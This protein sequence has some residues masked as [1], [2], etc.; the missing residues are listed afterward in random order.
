MMASKI[1]E[2]QLK[3]CLLVEHGTDEMPHSLY[4][5][6]LPS[7]LERQTE[8]DSEGFQELLPLVVFPQRKFLYQTEFVNLGSKVY[9]FGGVTSDKLDEDLYR[10]VHVL[11]MNDPKHGLRRVASLNASKECPCAF[12]AD[13]MIYTLGKAERKEAS[14]KSGC[15]ERY[16]P[17]IDRWEVLP[18][19]PLPWVDLFTADWTGRVTVVGREVFIGSYGRYAIFNLDTLEWAEPPSASLAECFPYGALYIDGFLYHLRGGDLWR[20]PGAVWD[21]HYVPK[22]LQIV[23]RGPFP[24][25]DGFGSS[26]KDIL[27]SAS[28]QPGK[29]QVMSTAA[30]LAGEDNTF[31]THGNFDPWRLLLHLGGPYFCY[32]VTAQNINLKCQTVDYYTRFVGIMIFKKPQGE[33]ININ[34][35]CLVSSLIYR[36]HT[37]FR[38]FAYCLRS[39]VLGDVPESWNRVVPNKKQESSRRTKKN[40]LFHMAATQQGNRLQVDK[41][42]SKESKTENNVRV[43]DV[44]EVGNLKK[45]LAAQ[46]EELSRLYS[47]LAKKDTLLKTY[48]VELVKNKGSI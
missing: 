14:G 40:E 9:I 46:E 11:D 41:D 38:N 22:P 3:I 2:S 19:P 33:N 48:E 29:A 21:P 45:V 25:H 6:D 16:I 24:K 32:L 12:V 1:N 39:C 30:E 8:V 47:E 43:G 5:I 15:F 37:P 27:K 26:S 44:E 10:A 4:T 13:G 23:R 17:R 34:E 20:R 7:D 18:D 35:S 42:V 28:L 31:F 36:I